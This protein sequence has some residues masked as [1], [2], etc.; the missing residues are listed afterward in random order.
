M[1]KTNSKGPAKKDDQPGILSLLKPYRGLIALLLLLALLSNGINLWIP[2]IISKG[3][4][5]YTQQHNLGSHIL[6]GFAMACLLI[7]IFTYLQSIVQTYVSEKVARDLRSELS[8][9]LSR[10]SH[11]FIQ[12]ANPSRLLTNLTS[13]I[14]SIKVFVS[15]AIVSIASSL[16]IIIGGAILLLVM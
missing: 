11:A 3:I 9:K 10:Q 6:F 2:R 13:D 4:D 12:Q 7:F 15:Q 16:F 8:D 14:D 1:D 5:G